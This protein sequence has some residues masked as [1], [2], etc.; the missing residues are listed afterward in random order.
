MLKNIV[1]LEVVQN[2]KSYIFECAPDSPLGEI[3]DVLSQMRGYV[4][5][6]MKEETQK[7]SEKPAEENGND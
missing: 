6:R 1:H 2:E 4:I 5:N 7:A 3:Y